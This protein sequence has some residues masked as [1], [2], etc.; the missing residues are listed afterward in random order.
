M[1]PHWTDIECP[2]SKGIKTA[3]NMVPEK[4][5]ADI[6][7]PD[8]KGIKTLGPFN[9]A[10]HNLILNALIQKG[11]RLGDVRAADFRVY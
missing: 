9:Q 1:G 4:T 3:V 8:S 5:R 7:C 11:L 10:G 2:D 6:E